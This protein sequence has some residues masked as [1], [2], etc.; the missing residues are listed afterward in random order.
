MNFA[1][2]LVIFILALLIF[3]SASETAA[4]MEKVVG[5]DYGNPVYVMMVLMAFVGMATAGFLL[6]E[7]WNIGKKKLNENHP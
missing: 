2:T 7:I 6:L 3:C 4:N 1:L 5:A